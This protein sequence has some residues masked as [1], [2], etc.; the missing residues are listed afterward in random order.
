MQT[1]ADDTVR[2]NY[3]ISPFK[4]GTTFV[5]GLFPQDV[6]A[7]EP[8][9]HCT[10]THIDNADFLRRRKAMLNLR[11]EASG[12]FSMIAEEFVQQNPDDNILFMLRDPAAWIGSALDY[13]RKIRQQVGFSYGRKLYWG[14]I[15]VP[16]LNLFYQSSDQEKQTTI[17]T[18]LRFWLRTYDVARRHDNCHMIKLEDLDQKIDELEDFFGM[19]AVN[20]DT[21]W[22]RVNKDRTSISIWD[23]VS[24][25]DYAPALAEFGY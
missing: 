12:F 8:L 14:R 17:D 10:L 22:R 11:V 4:T 15:G 2:T 6:S 24:R 23:H 3:C 1:P 5:A 21:A 20:A 9:A 13:G 25:Q 18:M 7:H 19:K 16:P